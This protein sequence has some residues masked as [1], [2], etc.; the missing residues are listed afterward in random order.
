M[1][2]LSFRNLPFR[3]SPCLTLHHRFSTQRRRWRRRRHG[4]DNSKTIRHCVFRYSALVFQVQVSSTFFFCFF[5]SAGWLMFDVIVSTSK[6]L[7]HPHTLFPRI[8]PYFRGREF[9]N[10]EEACFGLDGSTLSTQC[11]AEMF[12]RGLA[13][14]KLDKYKK[15]GFL[16]DLGRTI[17]ITGVWWPSG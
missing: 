6:G 4:E 5:F 3:Q 1:L 11:F 7:T 10:F 13:L 14:R 17:R 15:D 12:G 9:D 8:V 16:L 2:H